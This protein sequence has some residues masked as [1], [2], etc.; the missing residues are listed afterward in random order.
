MTNE[1][2]RKFKEL[3]KAFEGQ[4]FADFLDHLVLEELMRQASSVNNEGPLGQLSFLLE[5]NAV[6][7]GAELEALWH[8]WR[9]ENMDS[10]NDD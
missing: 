2:Q 7:S 4:H 8:V 9:L 5:N 3:R 6:A 1:I 10:P